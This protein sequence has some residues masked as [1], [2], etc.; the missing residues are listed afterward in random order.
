MIWIHL[1]EQ[2]GSQG[3][4][5]VRGLSRKAV[6]GFLRN[7][8]PGSYARALSQSFEFPLPPHPDEEWNSSISGNVGASLGP[9]IS[10]PSST[11]CEGHM[12]VSGF[13]DILVFQGTASNFPN[14]LTS[15]RGQGPLQ[16]LTA[17][18]FILI[19]SSPVLDSVG[20]GRSPGKA[21]VPCEDAQEN[22]SFSC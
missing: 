18:V 12:G 20:N 14:E 19:I 15:I 11:G 22:S 4:P 10:A 7:A 1:P 13:W 9:F 3:R 5:E 17:P 8:R 2:P 21:Q 6:S 16:G